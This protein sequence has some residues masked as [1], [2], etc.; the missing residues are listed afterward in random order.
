MHILRSIDVKTD[1]QNEMCGITRYL[2]NIY[3]DYAASLG[4]MEASMAQDRS[5]ER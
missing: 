3:E 5:N 2:Y 4:E 1:E